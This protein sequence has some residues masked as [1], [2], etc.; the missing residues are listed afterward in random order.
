MISGRKVGSLEEGEVVV[1]DLV[2]AALLPLALAAVTAGLVDTT[3]DALEQAVTT[4][5]LTLTTDTEEVP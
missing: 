1:A 3:V 2:A 4:Q 5:G